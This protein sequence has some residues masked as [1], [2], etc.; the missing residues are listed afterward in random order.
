MQTIS[1]DGNT[2]HLNSNSLF[3]AACSIVRA[4]GDDPT[5]VSRCD[6]WPQEASRV[7]ASIDLTLLTDESMHVYATGY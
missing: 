3:D 7:I 4:G 1:I 6:V 5:C 2:I